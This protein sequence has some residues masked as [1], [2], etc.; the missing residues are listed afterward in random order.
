M[1]QIMEVYYAKLGI[2]TPNIY[3]EI[4]CYINN[5]IEADFI[6]ACIDKAYEMKKCSWHYASAILRNSIA[7][8]IKTVADFQ[9]KNSRSSAAVKDYGL[10]DEPW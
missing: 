3:A 2:M 7:Q 5:N 8:G 4:R 1:E 9:T 10:G 6:V